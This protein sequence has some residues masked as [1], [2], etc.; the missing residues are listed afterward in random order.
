[1]EKK[2]LKYGALD[3]WARGLGRKKKPAKETEKE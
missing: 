1:M 2:G 3:L